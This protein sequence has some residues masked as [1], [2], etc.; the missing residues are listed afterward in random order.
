MTE[1]EN[2][3]DDVLRQ[4]QKSFSAKIYN[5]E[6]EDHDSLMDAFDISPARKRENRQYW[7]RELGMCWQLLIVEVCR[8]HCKDFGKA[9]KFGADEPYDL[10]VGKYAI[11]T[12]YRVGSGDSGTLKKF[13]AYGPLLK[14]KGYEPRLVILR[15]DNLAAAMTACEQGGWKITTGRESFDFI[16]EISGFDVLS[17]LN[18]RASRF[19][20]D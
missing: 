1:V 5:V 10:T 6:N 17:F 9:V 14:E 4:Y 18:N 19:A 16:K 7:G 12:K 8:R 11:D 3:L 15:E 2:R 13:K 20:V